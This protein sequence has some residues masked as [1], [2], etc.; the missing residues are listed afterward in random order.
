[1]RKGLMGAY[2]EGALSALSEMLRIVERVTREEGFDIEGLF[3]ATAF[4]AGQLSGQ[5]RN[6]L[7][8]EL[9]ASMKRLLVFDGRE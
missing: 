1:M 6:F 7:R 3:Y 4:Q 5:S 2:Q 8:N 9:S